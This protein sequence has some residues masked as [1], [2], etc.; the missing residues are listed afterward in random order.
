MKLS[1]YYKS[2]NKTDGEEDARITHKDMEFRGPV[3]KQ[4]SCTITFLD[5]IPVYLNWHVWN[6]DINLM[7]KQVETELGK[8]IR[9]T[10]I[11]SNQGHEGGDIEII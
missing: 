6:L 5:G 8:K 1:E 11:T 2:I 3:G 10:N 4:G 9:I 7:F